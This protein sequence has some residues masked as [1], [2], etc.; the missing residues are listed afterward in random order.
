M[1]VFQ[2]EIARPLVLAF[3]IASVFCTGCGVLAVRPVYEYYRVEKRLT[4][5]WNDEHD[6]DF[7]RGGIE[8][9]ATLCPQLEC[10]LFYLDSEAGP[11]DS[12]V[13]VKGEFYGIGARSTDP[14]DRGISLDWSLRLG[15]LDMEGDDYQFRDYVGTTS[16]FR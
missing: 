11:G 12:A 1:A 5:T 7:V 9:A 13:E 16:G 14:S 6:L 2:R 8:L 4:D 3:L 15:R 10:F